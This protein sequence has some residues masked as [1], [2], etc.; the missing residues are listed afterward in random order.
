MYSLEGSI[1]NRERE[2]KK[3]LELFIRCFLRWEIAIDKS[4]LYSSLQRKIR[5]TEVSPLARLRRQ[6][7]SIVTTR[8]Q[9]C[10]RTQRGRNRVAKKIPVAS[11]RHFWTL[12]SVN[13]HFQTLYSINKTLFDSIWWPLDFFGPPISSTLTLCVLDPARGIGVKHPLFDLSRR[14]A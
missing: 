14:L 5:I 13:R 11:R 9:C 2:E 7:L 12:S 8:S 3:H 4:K 10:M 6:E 1:R